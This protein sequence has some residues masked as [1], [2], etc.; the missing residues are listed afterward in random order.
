MPLDSMYSALAIPSQSG[1][2]RSERRITNAK[3]ENAMKKS[4]LAL[5]L[6]AL[7]TPAFAQMGQPNIWADSVKLKTED[8]VKAEQ[9]REAGYKSGLGKIPDGKAKK[10]PWGNVRSD[11]A[12][13]QSHAKTNAK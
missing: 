6:V 13:A 7:A 2:F 10:D 8:E 3:G 5:V 4:V 1:K 11:S 9:E 12:P